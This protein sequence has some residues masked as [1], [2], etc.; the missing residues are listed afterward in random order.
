MLPY[1]YPYFLQQ[2]GCKIMLDMY[3]EDGVCGANYQEWYAEQFYYEPP[4][5]DSDDW[6]DEEQDNEWIEENE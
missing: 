3:D 1:C 5:H 2:K 6:Y 4:C